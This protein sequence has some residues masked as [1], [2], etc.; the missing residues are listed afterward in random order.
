MLLRRVAVGGM[1]AVGNHAADRL[2]DCALHHTDP[3]APADPRIAF[4]DHDRLAQAISHVAERHPAVGKEHAVA[5]E[6]LGRLVVGIAR[7]ALLLPA[8]A[9]EHA[10]VVRPGVGGAAGRFIRMMSVFLL[11]A[12]GRTR[13]ERRPASARIRRAE[14]A[15][16]DRDEHR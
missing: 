9:A 4:A 12:T 11:I 6:G 7:A 2:G 15:G 16:N 5:R 14:E 1:V 10:D 8:V 3:E 13:I